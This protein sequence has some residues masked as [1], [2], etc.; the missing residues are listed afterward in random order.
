MIRTGAVAQGL[1]GN[2]A[3]AHQRAPVD[4]GL[5]DQLEADVGVTCS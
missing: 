3:V 4:R 2:V 5:R 1:V